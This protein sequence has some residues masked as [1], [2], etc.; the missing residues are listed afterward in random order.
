MAASR[1]KRDA[2]HDD[3]N[4]CIPSKTFKFDNSNDEKLSEFL[5]WC[6]SEALSVSRKVIITLLCM[7]RGVVAERY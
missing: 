4:F 6:A 2:K 1:E 5:S 7:R 3:S